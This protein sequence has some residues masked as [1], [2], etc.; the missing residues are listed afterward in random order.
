MDITWQ[1]LVETV[2]LTSIG[3]LLGVGVGLVGTQLLKSVTQWEAVVTPWAV[4][5]SI[6]VSM[7]TGIAFGLYPARKAAKM[8]PIAALRHE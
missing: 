1:F 7:L 2:T 5:L 3:G 4:A 6:G 8:E